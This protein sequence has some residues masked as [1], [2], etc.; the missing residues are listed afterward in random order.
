MQYRRGSEPMPAPRQVDPS[1]MSVS[2][3]GTEIK[4]GNPLTEDPFEVARKA[5]FGAGN[6]GPSA[7]PASPPKPRNGSSREREPSAISSTRPPG[8]SVARL[9]CPRCSS[10]ETY[11]SRS[12]GV[13]FER[14]VLR[15]FTFRPYRCVRCEKRF[16]SRI[17]PQSRSAAQDQGI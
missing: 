3:S 15:L 1:N 14:F 10:T 9:V 17:V 4:V 13:F 5:F 8:R 16:Y 11:R 12:R 2:P 6:P 7:S